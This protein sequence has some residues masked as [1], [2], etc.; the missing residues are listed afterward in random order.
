MLDQFDLQADA[1]EALAGFVVQLAADAAAL[2]F[3]DVQHML[4]QTADLFLALRKIFHQALLFR[5]P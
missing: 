3:L 1:Q 4:G 5:R 2:H